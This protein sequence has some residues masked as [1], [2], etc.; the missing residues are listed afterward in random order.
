MRINSETMNADGSPRPAG[1]TLTAFEPPSGPGVRTDTAAY[2]GYHIN[3]NFDSLLAKLI[4]HSTSA[5]FEDAAA[6]ARRALSEFRI[7][8]APTNIEF[9]QRL[10]AHPDF[11]SNQIDTG[12]V[13]QHL[14]ELVPTDE[15][16]AGRPRSQ[17]LDPL[18]V[19]AYGKGDTN[20]V[21]PAAVPVA[22]QSAAV[23]PPAGDNLV[24]RAPIQGTIVSVIANA[25]DAV[26]AGEALLVMNAMK[27]E[28]VIEAPVGGVVVR[29]D[30]SEGA[31]VAEGRRSPTSHRA[32]A[33]APRRTTWPP[34]ISTTT[35]PISARP[36]GV[37]R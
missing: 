23:P 18:A 24:A 12:F 13:Q 16:R 8:G 26:R 34:S 5:R 11:V 32:T 2:A 9:L 25:G 15:E 33:T 7:E 14:A 30:I 19:L 3:A 31:T 6:R 27:M 29:I 21:A 28:H 10:L 1:G 4:A 17:V 36:S 20:R 22:A 37:A 35:A